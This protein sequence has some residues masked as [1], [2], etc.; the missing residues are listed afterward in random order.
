MTKRG[1]GEMAGVGRRSPDR[2]DEAG[3][4]LLSSLIF[5]FGLFLTVAG[6][7]MLTAAVAAYVWSLL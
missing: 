1:H 6:V 2:D 4:T 3:H 5:A 7:G